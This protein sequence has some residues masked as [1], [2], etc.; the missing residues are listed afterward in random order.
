MLNV[1]GLFWPKAKTHGFPKTT[2]QIN[3][4]GGKNHSRESQTAQAF[5]KNCHIFTLSSVYTGF[6]KFSRYLQGL[7]HTKK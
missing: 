1:M 6:F 4:Y 3:V 7:A 2:P 5:A